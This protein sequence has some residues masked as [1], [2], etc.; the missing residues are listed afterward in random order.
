MSLVL[1]LQV[2]G[3]NLGYNFTTVQLKRGVYYP[4]GHNEEYLARVAT[5]RMLA[6]LSQGTWSLP[7]DIKS[8]AIDPAILKLQLDVQNAVLAAL[9]GN[10][11]L[12]V[13]VKNPTDSA[14]H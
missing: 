10:G 14:P 11:A 6:K 4:R 13:A 7:L 8:L 12:N 1:L 9:S 5:Y 3:E 2:I